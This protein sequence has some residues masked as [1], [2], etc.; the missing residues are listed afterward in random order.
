M[1]VHDTIKIM[2]TRMG[3][4]PNYPYYLISDTEMFNAF[5]AEGGFFD[6]FYPCP[7]EDL[8]EAYNLLKEYIYS[9]IQKHINDETYE[10]ADWIYSYMHM[11]T[12]TYQ[13]DMLDID[14][15]NTMA[16]VDCLDGVPQ[17]TV[18]TAEACLDVSTKWIKKQPSRSGRPPTVFGE[19]H[20]IKSLRLDEANVLVEL[21][22]S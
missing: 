20:V 4:L 22:G 15:L 10:L 9:E 13:S 16:N 3:Y 14:Y 19:P 7:C 17:F 18:D 5:T 8:R 6:T 12:I 2:Y 11:S 21:E 1:F